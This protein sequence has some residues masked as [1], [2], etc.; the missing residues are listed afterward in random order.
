MFQSTKSHPV[1]QKQSLLDTPW[2]GHPSFVAQ[3]KFQNIAA[4][5]S[6]VYPLAQLKFFFDQVKFPN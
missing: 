6:Q 3:G 1:P 4:S 5:S 2:G